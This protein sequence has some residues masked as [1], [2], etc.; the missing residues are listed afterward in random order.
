MSDLHYPTTIEYHQSFNRQFHSTLI[1]DMVVMKEE[2]IQET[3]RLLQVAKSRKHFIGLSSMN[4]Q[5][6][7]K[8]LSVKRYL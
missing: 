8:N 4:L 3:K 5:L 1:L 7:R 6:Q 2:Y